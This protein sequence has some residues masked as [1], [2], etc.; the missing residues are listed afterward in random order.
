MYVLHQDFWNWRTAHPVALGLFP[1]GL[2][3]H[4]VYT[5]AAAILMALL[6]RFAWP[7][8]LEDPMADGACRTAPN[9][10]KRP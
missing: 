7:G 8:H 4:I 6:V 5:V 10:G 3:Y 1:A 9:T 2:F